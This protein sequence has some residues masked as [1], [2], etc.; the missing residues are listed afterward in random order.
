MSKKL[1]LS[2]LLLLTLSVCSCGGDNI[3]SGNS[4]TDA[5]Q[6]ETTESESLEQ[7]ANQ[8]VEESL[9]DSESSAE[10]ESSV[11]KDDAITVCGDFGYLLMENVAHLY[12][13]YG[14][15]AEITVPETLDDHTVT[16]INKKAFSGND[17]VVE[18]T[19]GN[20]VVNIDDGAFSNCP[21]LKKVNISSSVA[22]I[23]T[24]CFDDCPALAEIAVDPV[25]AFYDSVDGVLFDED[26]ACLIKC[27][28]AYEA[29]EYK[30][31]NGTKNVGAYAF[32]KCNGINA[33]VMPA[34]CKL[35]QGSFFNCSN[36]S[37]FTFKG[38]VKEIP[39]Y[40]FFGCA[41]L[42]EFTVPMGTETVE[43]YS[44]FGCVGIKKL[45]LPE[46]VFSIADTAF[47]YCTGI[48]EAD[49][50]GECATNW[51]NAHKESMNGE[52]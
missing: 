50:N 38:D 6:E 52:N 20:G 46:T 28:Q 17:F 23:G 25:N 21:S 44:F 22:L 41:L 27:P 51:Y 47:K 2:L 34:G 19:V 43:E 33:V 3:A 26:G 16:V 5:S 45:S 12:A 1:L 4:L 31:P 13:Y 8:S 10:T 30:I 14:N 32:K 39:A 37:T 40:C 18:I 11:P 24:D 29:E 42:K 35:S 48:E 36:L 15:D 7:S 9:D 49:V